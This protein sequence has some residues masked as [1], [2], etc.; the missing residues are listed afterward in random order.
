MPRQRRSGGESPSFSLS[1][2]AALQ[3]RPGLVVRHL[4]QMAEDAAHLVVPAALH[5]AGLPEDLAYRLAQRAFSDLPYPLFLALPYLLSLVGW[6]GRARAPEGTGVAMADGPQVILGAGSPWTNL[7]RQEQSCGP[8]G[9][10][11][12]LSAV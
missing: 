8:A 3:N 4:R 7:P 9:L 5:P 12:R 1:F 2:Q 6:F 11:A 10:L